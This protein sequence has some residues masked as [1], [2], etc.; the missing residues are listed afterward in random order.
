MKIHEVLE[1]AK[2]GDWFRPTWYV[3]SGMAYTDKDGVLAV[4]PT[5]KGAHPVAS[6]SVESLK[7]DWV[8]VSPDVVIAEREKWSR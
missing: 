2:Q 1:K 5:M 6:T 8:F 3:G 7:S 4:V